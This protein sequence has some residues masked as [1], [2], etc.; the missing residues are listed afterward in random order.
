MQNVVAVI[1]GG[2]RGTRLYPLTQQRAK[3]SVLIAGKFRLVDIPMSN[4]IHS[5]LER[6]FILT[7]FN[8]ASLNRHIAQTYYFNGMSRRS[9]RILAAEQTHVNMDWFQGTADAVRQSLPYILETEEGQPSPEHV[10]ILAGD[11]LYRMDYRRMVGYHL[12]K[13][14]DITVGTTPVA[15]SQAHRFGILKAQA[16]RRITR[17]V[18]KP[19]TEAELAGLITDGL[20]A[21]DSGKHAEE[22]PYLAS[23]GIYVFKKEVLIEKLADETKADFGQD[24]LP[25]SI[26]QNAVYAYPF[27]DYW[28][29]IGTIKSFYE[30]NLALLDMVPRFNFYEESHPIYTYRYHLPSTKVNQ[31]QIF[32]SMLADGAIIDRSE[33]VRSIVGLRGIIRENSRIEASILMGADFY[34]SVE[35]M[36]Q[37]VQKGIPPIG[38]GRGCLI[39]NAIIDKNARIGDGTMLINKYDLDNVDAENYCIRDSIIVVPKNTIIPPGTTI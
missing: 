38:I 28:E 30:A 24:I 39:R 23:M 20:S 11:H 5:E 3:P 10:L 14:A 7:Q 16:N 37:N 4:C 13:E 29:D 8:S 12:M 1:L 9:V 35:Q 32:A 19:K 36:A 18:E 33:I 25:E 17:F 27:D 34:E 22:K 6:I 21:N 31:S 15:R 2:G 26:N